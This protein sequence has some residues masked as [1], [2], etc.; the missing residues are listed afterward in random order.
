MRSRSAPAPWKP[1]A[2]STAVLLLASVVPSPLERRS[3]WDRVGPDKFLHLVGHAGHSVTLANALRAERYTD[4][5]AAILAV[6]LSTTLSLASGR[7][8]R[9][10]PGRAFEYEDV[11][12]GLIGSALG[13]SWWYVTTDSEGE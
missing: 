4:R 7:L 3:E 11:V 1:A 10:V 5:E 8:Q 9:W 12:A 13:V 6:A 2:Y